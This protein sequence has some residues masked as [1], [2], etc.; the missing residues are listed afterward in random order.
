MSKKKKPAKA[1]KADRRVADS[2]APAGAAE[3][4]AGKAD[5]EGSADES[6]APSAREA[7]SAG[8]VADRG[9]TIVGV[10]ASAGGLDA[11]SAMLHSLPD[12]P[13]L[14]IV[15]VQ[16][17]SPQHS[18]VLATLFSGSTK[19]PVKQLKEEVTAVEA[20]NVYVIPPNH[21]LVLHEGS[22]QLLPRPSDISQ[23]NPI[24]V[25][26][27]S[28]A[29]E[30]GPPIGVILSGT[31]SDGVEGVHAI[32]AAG[33]T[34]IAQR[35]ETAKFD[36]MPRA[37]IATGKVDLILAPEEIG[38]AL[39]KL[40]RE[41]RGRS[42]RVRH[43]GDDLQLAPKHLEQIFTLLRGLSG[44]DFGQYKLP[45]I[46]RR[47][48][49]RMAMH[50]VASVD[51]YLKYLHEDPNEVRQLY[52]DILIHVTR[53]F[54]E[55]ESFDFLA[56]EIYP[57][58]IESRR[59][60][61]PLRIW[62]PACSTGEEAYSVAISLVEYLDD[63]ER[64]P[65]QV[66]ATDVSEIAIEQARAGVYPPTIA[67][68]VSENRL[69]RFFT[70]TDGSLRIGKPIR[71]LC[72]FAR[73]DLTRD[74][75][76]SKLDL[77]VCRNVLIYLGQA[78][79]KKLLGVFHYALKSTGYLMLATAESIG[80]H[81]ELFAVT[82]KKNRIYQKK[83]VENPAEMQFSAPHKRLAPRP[84]TDGE[85]RSGGIQSEVNQLIL[86]QFAP[87]GVIVDED[88]QIA[89]FRGQTGLFLEPAPGDASL[90]LL[91]MCREGLL[92][93]LRSALQ[94]AKKETG[95][96][97]KDG[98]RVRAN[99]GFR[100][101]EL[102]VYPL[103]TA[104]GRR[105]FFVAFRDRGISGAA[106]RPTKATNS[107]SRP[108]ATKEALGEI[109][110]LQ[111]EL[112]A[113]REYLQSIIQDLEAAN[114]E[115]QSANEEILSSNEELQSTNE[116]LDTAKEELQSTN[117][118]LNTVNEELHGRNEELARINSDLINLINSVQIAIVIV[119]NRLRIR[120]FTPMAERVLNLIPGDVGRPISQIK[121]NIDYPELER[122]M[123]EV[124]ETTSVQHREV[125]DSQGRW[126]SLT[127]RPYKNVDNRIDGAV[128]ALFNLDDVRRYEAE[129]RSARQVAEALL[130][131][132][133][134]PV[135]ILDGGLRVRD[136]NAPF[137]RLLRLDAI[138]IQGKPLLELGDSVWNP[139]EI[140]A[141]LEGELVKPVSGAE[142]TLRL[143]EGPTKVRLNARNVG[144]S[145]DGNRLAILAFKVDDER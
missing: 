54:R 20:N 10:G 115:L 128:L 34:I 4:R 36:G 40:S 98:L 70:R 6:V 87:A 31:A 42:V 91:K 65:I 14:A 17:L 64:I 90:N 105:H 100:D 83:Q 95:P 130:A 12:H 114:E 62:V 74:P 142:L 56:K 117:E 92:H 57:K 3:N 108:R 102:E 33:G 140:Q 73:Q 29:D 46:Q 132:V 61:S 116:E 59:P 75:P 94:A 37:A 80:P 43:T 139:A 107:K 112:M 26:F 138:D 30:E 19:L 131:A 51:H 1:S 58:L 145:D 72:V 16:H 120:R 124:I 84:R 121:P 89:Q 85:P 136:A 122:L 48:Q 126:Y 41:G 123:T 52:Q 76:F 133:S 127:I 11:F 67:D 88:L 21:H 69:R 104:G 97:R 110:R 38:P 39:V 106:A 63:R 99:G 141:M 119:D 68:D 135:L 81:A 66:F 109:D 2:S 137:C 125:R 13:G 82:D 101:V 49:R 77:I 129:A 111:R 25:F 8:P 7:E 18:S 28:L 103:Q 9:V 24:D 47:I 113:S 144:R 23:Y 118:E 78:M 60:D 96:V 79:Q 5:V 53:F 35:P 55:P 93:G 134:D 50:R 45:T 32:K 27:R 15:F 143:P 86:E 22:L 44:V 71:D